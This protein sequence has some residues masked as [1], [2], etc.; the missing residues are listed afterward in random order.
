MSFSVNDIKAARER[1]GAY[2]VQTPLLRVRQLDARLGCE[3]YVKAECMQLTGAFKLRGALNRVLT[4][5]K[6]ELSRGVVTASSGNHGRALAYAAKMMGAKATVVVPETATKA[7]V[8]GIRALGAEVVFSTV[9]ERFAVAQSICDRTGGI[10]VPPYNDEYVMAGQGTIGLELAEQ[11]PEL[12]HVIVP[13]A[14]GGLISGIS[15]AVKACMKGTKV[16][17]A[18]PAVRSRYA[19][20]I[21]AGKP[22]EVPVAPTVADALASVCPGEKCFPVVRDHVDGFFGVEDDAML[23]GMKLLLTEAKI[24]AEPSSCI[25]VGAILS[26]KFR[27]AA[28]E[29]VCFVLSGGN[30][31]LEQLD[32][33]RDVAL[34]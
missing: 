14:G 10:F 25:G 28:H 17:G 6:E 29:K 33:L 34:D 2:I 5:S 1:I 30:I 24:L 26:G 27:P 20:S 11:C 8:E 4:L 32:M 16:W 23:K 15:T 7:K 9:T 19:V 3:V 13:V 12:D 21:A 31:G 22:T 18:E